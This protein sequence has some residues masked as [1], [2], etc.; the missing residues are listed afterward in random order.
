MA[1]SRMV[2]RPCRTLFLCTLAAVAAYCAEI[3][4]AEDGSGMKIESY[5]PKGCLVLLGASYAGGWSE[6]SLGGWRVV[7]RGVGGDETSG[8]LARFDAEVSALDPD[9][10]LIWGFINDIFRSPREELSAK[11][12]DSR[13]NIQQLLD[14]ARAADIRPVLA[15]EITVR[16]ERGLVSE[17]MHLAGRLLGKESYQAFVNGNVSAMNE[18]LEGIA[19]TEGILLL[20]LATVLSDDAGYRSRSSAKEDGSHISASGY[21][22]LTAYAS[23]AL[24]ELAY[25]ER[26]GAGCAGAAVSG[27]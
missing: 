4:G 17:L 3:R 20:D 14:R 24:S 9:V 25:S 10:V 8:M 5:E 27:G 11:L 22:A 21:D 12:E 15:T 6:D 7:N 16:H 18:W 23:V 1:A 26:E 13:R 2:N 19:R